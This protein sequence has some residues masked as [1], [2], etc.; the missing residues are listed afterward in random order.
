MPFFLENSFKY[1]NSF[2]IIGTLYNSLISNFFEMESGGVTRNFRSY[3]G[4]C[5]SCSVVKIKRQ[6][7]NR[8]YNINELVSSDREIKR[9]HCWQTS[10]SGWVRNLYS[11]RHQEKL[12]SCSKALYF[13]LYLIYFRKREFVCK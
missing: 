11:S 12:K 2:F 13:I 6:Q 1:N 10:P 4:D 5:R 9:A 3:S 7:L 8:Y